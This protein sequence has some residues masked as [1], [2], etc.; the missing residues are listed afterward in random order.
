MKP[1]H[2]LETLALRAGA[3]AL[4]ALPR[5]AA[6]AVGAALGALVGAAGVRRKVAAAN[7][8]RAFPETDEAWRARVLDEHY[9]ELGRT[10]ADYA[11]MPQLVKSPVERV[12]ASWRGEEHITAA[13]ARGR[14]V[15]FVTGHLGHFEL[16]GAVT[17]RRMPLAVVVKPLSN[18]GAEA[19]ISQL[20]TASGMEPLPIGA[21]IRA[22]VKRLRAGGMVAMLADQ[23]ARRDGVFVP[24]F[25]IPSSTPAGPAWLSLATGAPI[26]FGYCVRAADGRYDG[27]FLPP[28]E[29]EGEASDPEAVRALTAAH[30]A[31]LER[32]IRARPESWFWLHKRWKTAPP[33]ATGGS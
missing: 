5:P 26:V 32:V 3:G 14:G 30:T 18:P 28:L 2:V 19:W 4:T 31:L 12:F 1:A 16:M 7:L 9:R 22:V 8:A 27:E 13:A 15:V 20:R 11:R 6:L 23:D 24:F 29:P 21:G 17:G 25:G 10:A 33:G